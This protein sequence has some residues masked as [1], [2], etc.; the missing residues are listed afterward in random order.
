M[1]V[2]CYIFMTCILIDATAVYTRLYQHVWKFQ[3]YLV[4]KTIVH[5]TRLRVA[6]LEV[7]FVY[8]LEAFW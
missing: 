2:T 5:I 6:W 1:D 7:I 8:L 4:K 3:K